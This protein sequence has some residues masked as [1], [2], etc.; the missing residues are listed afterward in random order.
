M[1]KQVASVISKGAQEIIAEGM[2]PLE[3]WDL[4]GGRAPYANDKRYLKEG[5]MRQGESIP[6]THTHTYNN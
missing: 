6:H 1:A 2:E 4:L 3:F 5:L